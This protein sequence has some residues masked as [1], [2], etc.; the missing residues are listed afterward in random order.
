MPVPPDDVHGGRAVGWPNAAVIRWMRER[1]VASGGDPSDIPD[2]PAALWRVATVGERT[3]LS[4]PTIYR[5]ASAGEFPRPVKLRRQKDE[6][7]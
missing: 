4:R 3:G 1:V 5:M 7:A 2:E 6:A